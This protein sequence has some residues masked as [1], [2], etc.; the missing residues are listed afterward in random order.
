MGLGFG[1]GC[2]VNSGSL[3]RY[4]VILNNI[5]GSISYSL[6][7]PLTTLNLKSRWGE[8]VKN[9]Y[10]DKNLKPLTLLM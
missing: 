4:D 2:T 10:P 1:V 8:Q 3:E 7:F 6:Y 5:C 9:L